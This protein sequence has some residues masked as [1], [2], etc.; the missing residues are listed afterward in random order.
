LPAPDGTPRPGLRERKK[1][2]TRAAIQTH[3]LRLFREQGYDATT[4]EQICDAVEISESTFFRYFPSKAEVVLQDEYDPLL[5]A[6]FRERLAAHETPVRAVRGAF[7]DV[8]DRLSEAEVDEQR[9]RTVLALAVP[10]LRATM[11]DQFSQA[12]D[13]LAGAAAEETG[14]PRDDVAVR[15]FAGAVV[16]AAIAVMFALR[17]DPHASFVDLLDQAFEQLEKGLSL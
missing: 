5:V 7:R 10:E 8:F 13:M 1:A 16:G 17:D 11:L 4:V 15:T 9:E 2:R 3:A 6:A 12:I 14:R